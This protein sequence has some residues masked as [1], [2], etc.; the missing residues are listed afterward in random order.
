MKRIITISFDDGHD[1]DKDVIELLDNRPCTIYMIVNRIKRFD[2]KLYAKVE[3]GC[4]TM[5]HPHL[6]EP[7]NIAGEITRARTKLQEHFQ[8]SIDC[9]AYPYGQ[10]T[11]GVAH[12]V[13]MAG[14]KYARLCLDEENAYIIPEP[15]LAPITNYHDKLFD[16]DRFWRFAK[17]GK[18]IHL[19]GHS[20]HYDNREKIMKLTNIINMVE[21]M[22]YQFVTN[23]EYYD[24]CLSLRS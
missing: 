1:L 13:S 3:I 17:S 10:T 5:N 22:G 12:I 19:G 8:Q 20:Y 23:S 18:P 4:H 7:C 2:K 21:S 24:Y 16:E 15:M 9:F 6:F 11:L 14:F